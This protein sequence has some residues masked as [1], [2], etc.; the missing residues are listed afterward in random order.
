MIRGYILIYYMLK[1]H[2]N[3]WAAE[4]NDMGL[5]LVLQEKLDDLCTRHSGFVEVACLVVEDT[6][7]EAVS[8]ATVQ[9]V[10]CAK[11]HGACTGA[12]SAFYH[13][14]NIIES[15]SILSHVDIMESPSIGCT[16]GRCPGQ[17]RIH[18][19]K[20]VI[21]FH[22]PPREGFSEEVQH[23]RYRSIRAIG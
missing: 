20:G 7:A 11:I 4:I 2:S 6:V 19:L 10:T 17:L 9:Q 12:H 18:M 23:A 15:P 1:L 5:C 13:T 8:R 21:S 14:S 16:A 22:V 3:S